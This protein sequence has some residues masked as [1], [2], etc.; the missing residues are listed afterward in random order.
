MIQ[1]SSIRP[2]CRDIQAACDL[3]TRSRKL[4]WESPLS[5]QVKKEGNQ[6]DQEETGN[7]DPEEELEANYDGVDV[8]AMPLLVRPIATGRHSAPP[9]G[10]PVLA[11]LWEL[12]PLLASMHPS[13]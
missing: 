11:P 3:D 9:I 6:E 2:S 7:G 10:K 1:L 8:D 13:T 5:Y 4:S 12:L